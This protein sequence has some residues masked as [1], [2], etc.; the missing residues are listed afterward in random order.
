MRLSFP[1]I[2][3]LLFLA[4]SCSDSPDESSA[5]ISQRRM[6]ASDEIEY[7]VEQEFQMG[8]FEEEKLPEMIQTYGESAEL[9]DGAYWKDGNGENYFALYLQIEEG[10]GEAQTCRIR[11]MHVADLGGGRYMAKRRL[12]D[13]VENCEFDLIMDMIPGSLT[14]TDLDSNRMA[15]ITFV[16]QM[17]CVSDV[18][19]LSAKLMMLE[20]G[21]KYAIRGETTLKMAGGLQKGKKEIDPSFEDAPVA[22]QAY[23]V[24]QWDRFTDTTVYYWE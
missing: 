14:V 12:T 9:V 7:A 10:R 19:P 8:V 6:Q 11:A 24:A 16:Y 3:T 23:A 15:E 1:L 4:V 22:L 2:F 5:D 13:F 21:D 20:N 18:S 17:G